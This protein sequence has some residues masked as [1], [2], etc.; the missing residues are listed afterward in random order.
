MP[1]VTPPSKPASMGNRYELKYLIRPDLAEEIIAFLEPHVEMDDYCCRSD[2]RSYTVRSIYFD[3]PDFK[4]FHEKANGQKAREKFR[5]RTYNDPAS[6]PVF[7]EH[8]RKDGCTYAKKR[9]LLT[10]ST[11]KAIET[12]D[13]NYVNTSG[14]LN[15]NDLVLERL[16][17][18][19]SRNAYSPVALVVYDREA[20]I[21]PGQDTTRVT[22]DRNLR[23]SMFP[24]L[25]QI[26]EEDRL[27]YLLYNWTILEVKFTYIVPRW[28]RQLSTRFD[29]RRQACSK[30][31]TS[32]GHFL[33][34]IPSYKDGVAYVWT[35]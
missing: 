4:C 32:V 12:L 20:Y 19:M 15:N 2:T 6:A 23:T 33:G 28:L 18:R 8:K 31:C 11:L 13:Y 21:Y 17:F 27:E 1:T 25:K 14:P 3:S 9:L 16:F 35:I 29:L 26:W 30:Y 7:L 24:D 5:I 34:E 22:F 10:A